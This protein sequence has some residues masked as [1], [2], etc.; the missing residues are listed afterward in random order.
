MS[1]AHFLA[2]I[3]LMSIVLLGQV[4]GMLLLNPLLH[5]QHNRIIYSLATQYQ[6]WFSLHLQPFEFFQEVWC[7][8][9]ECLLHA[10]A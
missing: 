1:S 6:F 3:I 10:R 4:K 7:Q 5:S 8:I 2:L 9:H